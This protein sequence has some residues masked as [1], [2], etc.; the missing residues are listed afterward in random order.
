[1]VA[2]I[3][4]NPAQ[5]GS[6]EDFD[7]YPRE[8]AAD[9]AKLR[10]AGTHLVFAPERE[11]VYPDGFATTVEV[12]R[13]S[14]GLC[15]AHRPEHFRGVATVVTKLLLQSLPDV[16]YFG[17]KDYQQLLVIRQLAR[18]LDIPVAIEGVPTW[19]EHDGLALS[20]RNVN[21]ASEERAIASAIFRVLNDVAAMVAAG[22]AV[23]RAEAWGLE[24]LRE[25]GL[26]RVEYLEVR[27]AETLAPIERLAGPGR[28]LAAAWLGQ[29]PAD[30]QRPR[31]SRSIGRPRNPHRRAG[32]APSVGVGASSVGDRQDELRLLVPR[33]VDP[34]V[35]ADL[36]HVGVYQG[37]A[38][39]LGID[40]GE[41][42]LRQPFADDPR[43]GAGIDQVV[44]D[45]PPLAVARR[46]LQDLDLT[47]DLVVVA[48]DAEGID[49]ADA[50]LTRDDGGGD[51][52]AARDPD[53]AG[54][55][56]IVDQAPGQRLGVA[57][58]LLP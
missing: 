22:E 19:R 40:G 4:V 50:Q 39:R 17:E 25:A 38:G 41:M 56:G 46:R 31:P 37:P 16:A 21:L 6:N 18:D 14:E 28:V 3:F 7:T 36:G 55:L 26:S 33:E 20:S 47:L 9:L 42:R 49:D 24:A 23:E 45:Q 53:D 13:L 30:R 51:Q 11:E 5:F 35:L 32:Q 57:M 27:D 34:S 2:T 54:P 43:G 12:G 52:S 1:M 15:G 29:H 58:Q 10:A 48:H 44:D 8:E